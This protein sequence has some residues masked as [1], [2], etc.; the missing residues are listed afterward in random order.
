M[1][2][3]VSEETMLAAAGEMLSVLE[4]LST[5][6]YNDTEA[7]PFRVC[8]GAPYEYRFP[9]GDAPEPENCHELNCPVMA[10]IAKAKGKTS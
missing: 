5:A 7:G 3:S 6:V 2:V 10:V 9:Y 1:G 4:E 8:C